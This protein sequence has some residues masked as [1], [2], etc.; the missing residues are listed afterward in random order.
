MTSPQ[1]SSTPHSQTPYSILSSLSLSPSSSST[2]TPSSSSSSSLSLS[3]AHFYFHLHP[4]SHHFLNTVPPSSFSLQSDF[5]VVNSIN[6]F[7]SLSSSKSPNVFY[8]NARSL[9]P[10]FYDLLL[11]CA[12][13]SPDII[14]VVE[15]WLSLE[16]SDSEVSIPTIVVVL[17]F[18]LI[19]LCLY[20]PCLLSLN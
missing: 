3:S 8:F 5:S 12:S 13:Y 11:F 6:Y 19:Q 16:I 20:L 10:K 18:L 2:T 7:P 1:A 9:L 15:T 17:L 4:P 14:C